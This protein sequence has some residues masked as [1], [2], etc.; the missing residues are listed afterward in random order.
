MGEARTGARFRRPHERRIAQCESPHRSPNTF[1][2]ALAEGGA[3]VGPR[4]PC[5]RDRDLY[6][7]QGGRRISS[8]FCDKSFERSLP[9]E[10]PVRTMVVVVVLPFTQ[11]LVEQVDVVRDAWVTARGRPHRSRPAISHHGTRDR[12][13]RHCRS[14]RRRQGSTRVTRVVGQARREREPAGRESLPKV[15]A[16]ARKSMR[17][18]REP[19]VFGALCRRH[20]E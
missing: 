7:K 3:S 12:A 15:T 18:K 19:L 14:R 6:S 13:R 8:S 9:L 11:F 5:D 4:L 16:G 17:R 10:G 2:F 1:S 20:R